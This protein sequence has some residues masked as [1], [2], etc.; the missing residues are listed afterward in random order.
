MEALTIGAKIGA[1]V[2]EG[3][4]SKE[5]TYKEQLAKGELKGFEDSLW[6]FVKDLYNLATEELMKAAAKES[7]PCQREEARRRRLGKLEWRETRVQIRTGRYVSVCGLYAK[8]APR[9]YASTGH[10][11]RLHW[12]V[13]KGASAGYYGKVG[14]L[15]VLCPSFDVAN[16][17]LDILGVEC[18]RERVRELAEALAHHCRGR[19]AQLSRREGESLKGKRVLIGVDG[20]RTRTRRYNGMQ[21]PAGHARFNTPWVEPKM[22]V[23]DVL[24]EQGNI[25]RKE[26]PLYGCL[27]GD[28]ELIELLAS[29]LK[30]LAIE[31]AQSVQIVADGAPWIWNRVKTMLC[32]LGVAIE[33]IIETVDYYHASQYVHKIVCAL[34][35]KF[36]KNATQTL[37]EFKQWLWQGNIHSIT[38]KCNQ[39]FSRPSDE[40]KRYIGYLSKNLE[41]MQYQLFR[42]KNLVCGSGVI[43][44]GIRRVINLRFK[45]SSAFWNP[46]N[47]EGLFFLRGIILSFRWK[48][49]MT[50][51]IRL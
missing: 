27:F 33:K 5:K 21:N 26:L 11:L 51:L 12:K 4:I 8:K 42:N 15:G 13:L 9:G 17:V 28:D 31:Q 45:N 36:Q 16:Q 46:Q 41:R 34:P 7:E 2:K 14:L 1:F 38:E 40:I 49:L 23:I 19:Q 29:H 35:K 24:D 10:V 43:E 50:N 39:L 47:V 6:G 3:L 44:S 20:G 25:E 22:F 48:S 30:G 37:K 32:S 18:N